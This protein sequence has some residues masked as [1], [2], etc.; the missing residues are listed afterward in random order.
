MEK[1]MNEYAG[2]R[3]EFEVALRIAPTRASAAP[4]AKSIAAYLDSAPDVRV[5][6]AGLSL[7]ESR[8]HITLAITLGTIDDI[9]VAAPEPRSAVQLLQGI[10]EDLR[11]YDPALVTLPD[12]SSSEARLAAVAVARQ[13]TSSSSLGDTVRMLA[14]VA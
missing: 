11:C 14:S 10:V 1:R 7:D 2:L 3:R 5:R 9:K 12:P 4:A 6:I 8:L 13:G